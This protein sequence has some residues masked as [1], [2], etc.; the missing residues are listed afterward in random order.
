MEPQL[1]KAVSKNHSLC[2]TQCTILIQCLNV[3]CV[4][5]SSNIV[6]CARIEKVFALCSA[7]YPTMQSSMCNRKKKKKKM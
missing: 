6:P 2:V 7:N 4:N 1:N 3:E 5:L